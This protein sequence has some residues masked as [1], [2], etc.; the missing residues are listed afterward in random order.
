MDNKEPKQWEQFKKFTSARIGLHR[1]GGSIGTKDMLQ[2]RFDHAKA[3][4]AVW[5]KCDW[6]KI[7]DE[8]K[9]WGSV[10]LLHTKAKSR[11]EYLLKPHLG[12]LLDEKSIEKLKLIKDKTI[13]F[14]L[15]ICLV[16]GLSPNAINLN[17][18]PLLA[19]IQSSIQ[20][21]FPNLAPLVCIENGRVAIGDA[22]SEILN[23]KMVLVLIGERPGLSSADSIGAY[24]TYNAKIG[25]TDE[26]RNCISNIR[27]DG[28]DFVRAKAKLMYLLEEA[29]SKKL[30]GVM[31]KDRMI[32]SIDEKKNSLLK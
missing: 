4:D 20:K 7:S 25:T 6:D 1:S 17:I 11:E 3:K 26:S 19:E 10:S 24:I 8:L 14:D 32:E 2:F 28:L 23:T 30:T 12:R 18:V 31:L 21:L 29:V 5:G 27:P 9:Y 16:D 15:S 13:A 22:V